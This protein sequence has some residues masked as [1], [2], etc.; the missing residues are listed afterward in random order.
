[1]C[2]EIK[3][4][5]WVHAKLP[6]KQTSEFVDV[7]TIPQNSEENQS[8]RHKLARIELKNENPERSTEEFC[9]RKMYTTE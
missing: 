8:R 1:M 3:R 4:G 2:G 5:V 7:Q 6:E 9:Q